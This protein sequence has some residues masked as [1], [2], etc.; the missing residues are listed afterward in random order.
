V[1]VNMRSI[2]SVPVVDSSSMLRYGVRPVDWLGVRPS[3]MGRGGCVISPGVSDC[4]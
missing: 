1:S 4:S 3:E 2:G